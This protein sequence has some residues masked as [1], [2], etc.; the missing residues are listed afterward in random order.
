MTSSRAGIVPEVDDGLVQGVV[1]AEGAQR[2][3]SQI[4]MAT[5]SSGQAEPASREDAKG[6][7]VRE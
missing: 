2:G 6:V 1:I 4:E 7:A 5:S 3:C